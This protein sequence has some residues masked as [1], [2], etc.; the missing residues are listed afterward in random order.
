MIFFSSLVVVI[1]Q[2]RRIQIICGRIGFSAAGLVYMWQD[3]FGLWQD[4]YKETKLLL[5][6]T[7]TGV[8]FVGGR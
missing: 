7:N 3:W 4:F 5:N 6:F 1:T 2:T 8:G